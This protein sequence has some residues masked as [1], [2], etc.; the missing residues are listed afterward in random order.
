VISKVTWK[1]SVHEN[2]NIKCQEATL[3]R[4]YFIHKDFSQM[5]AW[6]IRRKN[7]TKLTPKGL[8]SIFSKNTPI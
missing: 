2:Q 1:E 5:R 3:M 7:K 6:P 8:R 4:Y